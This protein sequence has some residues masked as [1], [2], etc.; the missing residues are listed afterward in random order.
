MHLP[1]LRRSGPEAIAAAPFT[2]RISQRDGKLHVAATDAKGGRA[3]AT[4]PLPDVANRDLTREVIAGDTR[5]WKIASRA[6]ERLYQAIFPPPIADLWQASLDAAADEVVPIVLQIDDPSLA[7]LPWELLR[8]PERERFV[9]LSVRTPMS[10]ARLSNGTASATT[11]IQR[12]IERSNLRVTMLAQHL[13]EADLRLTSRIGTDPRID[14]HVNDHANLTSHPELPHLLIVGERDE[15]D[16]TGVEP[17]TIPAPIPLVV[18][19]RGNA[20][21]SPIATGVGA[22][23]VLPG[24]MGAEA[25][26]TFLVHLTASLAGG[27]PVDGAVA[28]A[29]RAVA[30]EH[31][32]AALDWAEPVLVAAQPSQPIVVPVRRAA[33]TTGAE[34]AAKTVGWFRDAISGSIS[35]VLFL[36]AGLLVYRLGF[37]TSEEIELDLLS[38]YELFSTFKGMILALSTYEETILLGVACGL[39]LLTGLVGLAMLWRRRRREQHAPHPIVGLIR[40]LTSVRVL[41]FLSIATLTIVGAYFYQQYLWRVVLPIPDGALGIAVTREAAAA[42]IRED[43]SGVLFNQGQAGRIVVRDLPVAFDGRD[44]EKARAL[45][46]RIG[47]R[48]VLIYREIDRGEVGKQYSAYVVFTD[49]AAGLAIGDSRAAAAESATVPAG[50]ESTDELIQVREGVEIP[51]LRADT[52]AQLVSSAAGVIAYNENRFRDAITFF[53]QALSA[54]P[55][56]PNRGL[57]NYYL[58]DSLRYDSQLEAAATVL[59]EAIAFYETRQAAAVRLTA[60][61]EFILASA[62]FKRGWIAGDRDVEGYE[63]AIEW[64]DRALPLR[65]KILARSD[66]L[67]RP[68]AARGLFARIYTHLAEA[69]RRLNRPD[70][71]HLWEERALEEIDLLAQ[72]APPND[73]PVLAQEAGARF[74]LGDCV[75]SQQALQRIMDFDPDAQYA[76]MASGIILMFR[77]WPAQAEQAWREVLEAHP[78]DASA[79][80]NLSLLWSLQAL[81]INGFFEPFYLERS[82]AFWRDVLEHDP[83]NETAHD[84]IADSAELRS[85]GYLFDTTAQSQGDVFEVHKSQQLWPTD[86]ARRAEAVAALDIVIQERRILATEINPHQPAAEVAL[87]GAY[88][89]RQAVHM[90]AFPV[91]FEPLD[92]TDPILSEAAEGAEADGAEI[93]EWTTSVLAADSGATRIERLQAWKHAIDS[94]SR[95]WSL[96]VLRQ[97]F[98]AAD[99]MIEERQRL[100]EGAL[101]DVGTTP[102]T[103]TDEALAVYAIYAEA[104]LLSLFEGDTEKQAEYQTKMREVITAQQGRD[105]EGFRLNTTICRSD[106]DVRAGNDAIAAN[107]LETARTHFDTALV[108]DPENVTALLARAGLRLRQNDVAGA[109][110]DATAAT[111]LNPASPGAWGRLVQAELAAGDLPAA[112]AALTQLLQVTATLPP[113][114]RMISVRDAI[115]HLSALLTSHPDGAG[116]VLEVVPILAAHLDAMPTDY[117][118]TFQYPQLY[119]ELGDLALNAGDAASAE[120]LLRRAIAIDP[121][122]V[123]AWANLALARLAAGDLATAE[124]EIDGAIAMTRGPVWDFDP[125]DPGLLRRQVLDLMS[126]QLDDY[127]LRYPDRREV[128][129]PLGD[130]I[131]QERDRLQ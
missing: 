95:L 27:H 100:L 49:P 124:A 83:A 25:R 123:V 63:T 39:L 58:G 2:V 75:G 22:E 56:D 77:G 61:D 41:S 110:A 26:Q 90:E 53:E 4:S 6:G 117:A 38:P 104:F 68:F 96:A 9:T 78:D 19:T 93:T 5:P 20:A 50:D 87:A 125:D 3:E 31:S 28:A 59:E 111:T 127:L 47:A 71:Q 57:L 54:D 115:E 106:R 13:D 45:G 97:D 94:A 130:A 16:A 33:A 48:A 42:S 69:N 76:R 84:A 99:A 14:I 46:K 105:A 126:V 15:G 11:P 114:E 23:V 80:E 119:A 1:P 120:P 72:E 70:E 73:T 131:A 113:Q 12:S 43:L 81:N 107:D 112:S 88:S 102:P 8:D 128:V 74:I 21:A 17:L 29:R 92:F 121:H 32:V 86:P 91:T 62:Y 40:P 35:A 30:D 37:S 129:Q 55:S 34:V 66:D 109:V 118:R 79:R 51:A 65:E 108:T 98:A 82:E 89:A 101:V 52:V 18:L 24:T 10:R 116:L 67:E 64:Y 60:E 36:I 7:A 103:T 122:Q 44:T 85:T